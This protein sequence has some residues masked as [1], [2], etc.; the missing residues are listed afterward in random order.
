[1]VAAEDQ[2]A[3]LHAAG[4]EFETYERFPS[5]VGVL[6]GNVMVL[7]RVAESGLEM[8]GS[9]G[10]RMVGSDGTQPRLGV[11]VDGPKGRMFRFKADEVEATE[12]RLDEVEVFRRE[13]AAALAGGA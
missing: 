8:I 12:A 2:L 7:L 4:F 13:L 6:R 9:A 1:M 5:A 10:W 11:L 3:R